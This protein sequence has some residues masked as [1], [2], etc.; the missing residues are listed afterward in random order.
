MRICNPLESDARDQ[1][2]RLRCGTGPVGLIWL[3]LS[4][5]VRER[6]R[7]AQTARQ[8]NPLRQGTLAFAAWFC[9]RLGGWTGYYGKPGP[10]VMLRV[11][12]HFRACNMVGYRQRCVSVGEARRTV[13]APPP[14]ASTL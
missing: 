7:R 4:E 2:L 10:V 3:T 6:R 1:H 12:Y 8:R 11:L 5:D 14:S 9:A 13:V